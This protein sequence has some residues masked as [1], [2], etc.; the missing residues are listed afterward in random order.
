MA[1]F[2]ES[3]IKYPPGIDHQVYIIYKEFPS[4][5]D[6][7]WAVE[8][9]APLEP[10]NIFD[11]IGYNSY[12]G[13]CFLEASRHVAEPLLCTLVSTSEVM[14]PNWLLRLYGAYQLP[15]TGL[16]GCTGSN[17]F[18]TE[19][20]PTLSYPNP[21]IRD[22]AIIIDR[23]W[24]QEIAGQFDFKASKVGYLAFEHG[25][26][27]LTRQVLNAGKKV[28]VVEKERIVPPD[29]WGE[30]TYRGNLHN[31][32]VHDRGARDFQDL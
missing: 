13:G 5:K 22:T 4:K 26:K 17:G 9:F 14:C 23:D 29:M 11:Y 3:F 19:F 30:T 6:L 20:F 32:L 31:V 7:D 21:H 16:V 18:I 8:Q 15:D 1:R 12:G 2:A 10:V 24:Y 25:P 28:W 27:G